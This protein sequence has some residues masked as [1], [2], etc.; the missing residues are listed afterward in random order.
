[1]KFISKQRDY[2]AFVKGS[3]TI[4]HSVRVKLKIGMDDYAILEFLWVWCK[5]KKEPANYKDYWKALGLF[6]NQIDAILKDLKQKGFIAIGKSERPEPTDLWNKQFMNSDQFEELWKIHPKGTK[7]EAEK[8]F[9]QAIKIA[10]YEHLKK[11]LMLYIE[12]KKDPKFRLDLSGWLNPEFMR[13]DNKTAT[14]LSTDQNNN[15][16]NDFYKGG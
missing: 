4:D 16:I 9:P 14:E 10:G 6:P 1:M 8:Y 13:W 2:T 5:K 11:R 7:K 3:S 12:D 15:V